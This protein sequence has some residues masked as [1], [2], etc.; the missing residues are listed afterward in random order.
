L[1]PVRHARVN[2]LWSITILFGIS[3]GPGIGGWLSEYHGWHSI[4]YVSLPAV[5]FIALAALL[6]LP[7]KKADHAPPFDFFGFAAFSAG[8]TG[9]QMFLD[10]GERLDWFASPEIWIEAIASASGFYLFVVHFLTADKHFI[11]KALLRDRNFA[12][13]AI[14][15]FA[16]GFV[17]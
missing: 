5:A 13:S 12:L 11:D 9:L 3:T 2:L 8:M 10:R 16:S 14:M 4:F 15:Y 7:E 1:P 6:H 17:L